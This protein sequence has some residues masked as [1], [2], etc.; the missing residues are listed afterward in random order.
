S[1]PS[2]TAGKKDMYRQPL[3]SSSSVSSSSMLLPSSSTMVIKSGPY[4]S[5][6]GNASSVRCSGPGRGSTAPVLIV[7]P[8][9]RHNASASNCDILLNFKYFSCEFCENPLCERNL[10]FLYDFFHL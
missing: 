8:A 1:A 3:C 4:S 7:Y 10:K 9:V 2:S 6:I 5:L